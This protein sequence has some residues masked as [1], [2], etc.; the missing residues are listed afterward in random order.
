MIRKEAVCT[1]H[2]GKINILEM[3]MPGDKWSPP[4]LNLQVIADRAAAE[5]HITEK[6]SCLYIFQTEP[7]IDSVYIRFEPG[8]RR[9]FCK[10]FAFREG[11]IWG[12]RDEQFFHKN[13]IKTKS[14]LVQ[15][16]VLDRIY[17]LYSE[18]HPEW[19]LQRHFT[20]G[21]RL[22]DHIYHCMKKNTVK[23][24]LY[25]S[26]LDEFAV[27]ID[28]MDE[29]NLVSSKPS[30]LYD[31]IPIRVLRSMNCEEG[32]KILSTAER[33]QFIRE[34]NV[35]F[36][37]VFDGKLNEA[38]C[39]YLS[40]LISGKLTVGETGRLFR[41][42]KRDYRGLWCRSIY[43]L[44]IMGEMRILTFHEFV[45]NFR[46]MIPCN[47][48]IY[49]DYL[50]KF[51]PSD[52]LTEPKRIMYY[53]T[54]AKEDYDIRFRQSNRKRP[55]DWQERTADYVIRYPQTINDFIRESLYMQNCLLTY[56]EAYVANDT[57]ILFMRKTGDANKPFITIEV[58]DNILMQ[59]YHRFN[60]DCSR[61]E[62]NWIV[63]WCQRHEID[64]S[65]FRFDN[66]VDEL[67]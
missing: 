28:E 3:H 9:P 67:Y 65:H 27:N 48:P 13:C 43:L 30:D 66:L 31:G 54:T 7:Y 55:Y 63:D 18:A 4:K 12:Y 2:A 6:K 21:C 22:L 46:N 60:H 41:A 16:A 38:Q 50:K 32:A 42:K 49:K 47:D 33:R 1:D 35:K 19:H 57:T 37:D 25:K 51:T 36:P 52:D 53:L 8:S 40:M 34:L 11:Y 64:T 15:G 14:C 56:L 20:A 62:A 23:E 39:C 17:S 59:A 58:Q 24:M 29:I 5:F 10:R 61:E 44:K 26:G 45:E